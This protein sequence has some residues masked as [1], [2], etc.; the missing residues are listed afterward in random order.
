MNH[1]SISSADCPALFVAIEQLSKLRISGLEIY[2]SASGKWAWASAR[3]TDGQYLSAHNTIESSTE[4][5]SE[6]GG[7]RRAP[8]R[9]RLPR[10]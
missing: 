9:R 8:T 6:D 5:T 2:S 3:T 4:A 7:L 1:I 10:D